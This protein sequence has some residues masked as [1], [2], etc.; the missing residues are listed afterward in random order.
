MIDITSL[1]DYVRFQL[2][3]LNAKNKHHTFEDICYQFARLAISPTFLPA[4]GPVSAGGDQGRDSETF[5]SAIATMP[6]VNT[7][8]SFSDGRRAV[9]ACSLE[10]GPKAKIE[11]DVNSICKT[12]KKPDAIYFFS[13]QDIPVASRHKLQAWAS[14]THGI[15]LEILDVNALA[16]Q[17]TRIELFWIAQRYLNV[18]SEMYPRPAADE[19]EKYSR[20]RQRW[21]AQKTSPA[22]FSDFMDIKYGIRH[23]TFSKEA[24]IDIPDWIDVL[25]RFSVKGMPEDIVRRS[26]YEICVAALR[27]LN[28]LT[29]HASIVSEYFS[30]ID[31]LAGP[32]EIGDAV[33]L[34]SYCSSAVIYRQFVFEAGQL[35]VWTK[36]LISRIENLLKKEPGVN[37]K[38]ELLQYRAHAATLPFQDGP[39]PTVDWGSPFK[40]WDRLVQE[41]KHAPLFPLERFAN[42]LTAL[43]PAIGDDPRFASL[44]DRVDALLDSRSRGFVA[45]EKCRDRAIAFMEAGRPLRAIRE[46]HAA[47]IK[48]FAEETIRGTVLSM[49]LLSRLYAD[50]KLTWAAKYYALGAGF[51]IHKHIGDKLKRLLPK[52]FI[53]LANVCYAGG[54]WLSFIDLLPL[55]GAAQYSFRSS[56]DDFERHA[57]FQSVIM[58][59]LILKA[60]GE[61]FGH[62]GAKA[63][64]TTA[65]ENWPLP[66]E[67]NELILDPPAGALDWIMKWD[68]DLVWKRIDADL[69]GQPFSDAGSER[70]YAWRSLGICWEV[71]CESSIDTVVVVEGLVSCLQ[72]VIADIADTELNL[73]PTKVTIQ[74][75]VSPIA[76]F[77]IKELASNDEAKWAIDLPM[78]G[79]SEYVENYANAL[80]SAILISC[81][82]LPEKEVL[83][84]FDTAFKHGLASK[85]FSVRPY[86]ELLREFASKERESMRRNCSKLDAPSPD[87]CV[88]EDDALAWRVGPGPGYSKA[89]S[90]EF[91]ANRY[92]RAPIPIRLTLARLRGSEAFQG[93]VE[94]LRKQ[95]YLDWH[96]LLLVANAVINHRLPAS[97]TPTRAAFKES[98]KAALEM[99]EREESADTLEF[100]ELTITG[101]PL[102]MQLNILLATVAKTWGFDVKSR[103]PDFE[104][105]KKVLVERY[106]YLTDDVPH[107]PIFD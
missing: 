24:K 87:T 30:T 79:S 43:V 51:L 7:T 60:V 85:T 80:A 70:K 44:T 91:I 46:L 90:L 12:G 6:D 105:L 97:V 38:C 78:Q 95:G 89:Q 31:A 73:L 10:K 93:V 53:Q 66:D 82:L 81:S 94:G 15:H 104:A 83:N 47:K 86:H 20:Q 103:T 26:H 72:I 92:R 71:S 9:L 28:D 32:Q 49:L 57:D 2:A 17:L 40:W 76:T 98:Q 63:Y 77:Q 65:L 68:E 16:E 14:E 37:S 5:D 69:N 11:R 13:N 33:V 62:D 59:A 23:A 84:V 106:A 96:I 107:E 19:D 35:H 101:Q 67:L 1:G 75:I 102:D 41:I 27:G 22:S 55:V 29:S 4:T 3:S 45:A 8:W 42:Q 99:L 52:A 48:W 21:I 56:P 88:H 54:E 34:L 50:L 61:R 36:A 58:H 74:A 25:H 39:N 64:L 18:A 100:P